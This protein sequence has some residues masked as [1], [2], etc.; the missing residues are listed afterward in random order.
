MCRLGVTPSVITRV[1]N[2]PGVAPR[3]CDQAPV[4]DQADLVG[5]AGVEVVADDLLEEH[6]PG[7]RPVEHLGQGELGLQIEMS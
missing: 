6:P 5:A 7:D 1:R 3:P 4:E 2:R